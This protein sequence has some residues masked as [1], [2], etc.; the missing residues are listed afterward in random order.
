[1]AM[2]IVNIACA[3]CGERGY[4]VEDEIT[5]RIDDGEDETDF[6]FCSYECLSNW[7]HAMAQDS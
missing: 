1:M 4:E 3:M 7:A 5:V 6:E 2:T